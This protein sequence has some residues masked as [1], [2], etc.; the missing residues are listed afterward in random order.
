M[1]AMLVI[2]LYSC[3]YINWQ[4]CYIF[5]IIAYFYSS[6]K[7][8]KSTEQVLPG[9]EGRGGKRVEAGAGG[10]NDS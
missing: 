5:L 8:E 1:K 6:M 9:R 4:K 7:L 3:P 10:R 2:S